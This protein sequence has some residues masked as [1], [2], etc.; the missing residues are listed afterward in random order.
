MFRKELACRFSLRLEVGRTLTTPQHLPEAWGDGTDYAVRHILRP[1][2]S[3]GTLEFLLCSALSVNLMP[4]HG[5]KMADD[6]LKQGILLAVCSESY[7]AMHLAEQAAL[8]L[9][10]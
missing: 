7:L 2:R 10:G 9:W 5:A 6:G 4:H 1:L 8:S 3:L